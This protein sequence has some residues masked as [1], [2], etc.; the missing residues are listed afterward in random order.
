MPMAFFNLKRDPLLQIV[1]PRLEP[2]EVGQN[3]SGLKTDTKGPWHGEP[4]RYALLVGGLPQRTEP[5][6]NSFWDR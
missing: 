3:H 5:F 1:T 4:Q 2:R 6:A